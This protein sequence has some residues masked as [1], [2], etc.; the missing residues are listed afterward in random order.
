MNV[1]AID[2]VA[3]TMGEDRLREAEQRRLVALAT[4]G[5]ARRDGA[6]TTRTQLQATGVGSTRPRHPRGSALWRMLV[7]RNPRPTVVDTVPH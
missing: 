3:R 2:V 7:G 6:I 1:F 4:Q 5:D